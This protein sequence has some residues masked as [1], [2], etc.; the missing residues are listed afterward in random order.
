MENNYKIPEIGTKAWEK[1]IL[2]GLS[3]GKVAYNFFTP[4]KLSDDKKIRKAQIFLATL[5][6][7]K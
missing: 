7:V 2:A 6:G 4:K 3:S 5:Q 1:L